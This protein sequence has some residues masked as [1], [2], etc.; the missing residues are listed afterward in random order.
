MRTTK[1]QKYKDLSDLLHFNKAVIRKQGTKSLLVHIKNQ[2]NE[3]RYDSF[4]ITR[5]GPTVIKI[6]TQIDNRI[7]KP[8]NVKNSNTFFY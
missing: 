8:Y 1:E 5:T 7:R 2:Y 4:M 3:D 6:Y